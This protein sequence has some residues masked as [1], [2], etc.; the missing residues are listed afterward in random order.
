MCRNNIA[1]QGAGNNTVSH[2]ISGNISGLV[3]TAEGRTEPFAF[4]FLQRLLEFSI[5]VVSYS[6]RLQLVT[7]AAFGNRFF[8]ALQY[9]LQGKVY[10][11]TRM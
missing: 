10:R 2:V 11:A 1:T 7:S 6:S 3:T 8:P 5:P 9:R 4:Y